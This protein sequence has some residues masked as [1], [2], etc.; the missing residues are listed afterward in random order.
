MT[1]QA[2]QP[3]ATTGVPDIPLF[4][5]QL[6]SDD[7]AAVAETLRS[8]WLTAGPRTQAFEDAFAEHLGCRHTIAV[9][10]CTAALHL[11]YLA[12]GV[13]PGDEVIVPSYTFAATASSVVSCGATPVF[14]DI[15]G[16]HDPSLDP[17][18]VEARITPRT[19]AVAVVHF[20]GYA[21]PVDRLAELCDA[22]GIALIEDTAHAP[23]A[24]LNGRMLGT[25]G[26]AS[27]FSLFSNKVLSVGEGGLLATD[28]DAIAARVRRLRSH[29]MTSGTWDRHN[30]SIELYDVGELGFN[31]RI[32]EPR[33]ALALS[34]L[35][36]LEA[37]IAKRRVLTHRY[38]EA[39]SAVPGLIVP[40]T[41]ASVD[42]SSCYVMPIMLEDPSRHGQ[43]RI[44]LRERHGV[45]TSLFYPAIHEFSIYRKHFPGTSLPR[46][47]LASR[48]EITIPLFA[49]LTSEQQE[50]VIAAI[51]E[52]L[53]P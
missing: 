21:A 18:D 12:A 48:S 15:V 49:H 25:F 10:S 47:E 32:D 23:S 53:A 29:A 40:F 14:A 46:T 45:Q 24:T 6:T 51:T 3:P 8:G 22:H 1:A 37:D 33:S 35:H 36:G 13:G 2:S 16:L 42:E 11:A 5:L 38:R 44:D 34:R 9:S 27:A 30:G 7:L 28:D 50:R 26:L 20:A 52:E 41:D 17:D 43:L 19:K 39:L 4:D 31:Y